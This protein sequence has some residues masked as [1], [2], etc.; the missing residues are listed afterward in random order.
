MYPWLV[1]LHVLGVFGFLMAHGVTVSAF[2]ALRR[3]RNINRIQMLL[4]MSRGSLVV[5]DISILLLLASGIIAG[6][7]GRWWSHAWIWVSL[8]LLF[9]I[10]GAMEMLGT[11]SLNNIRVALG[12]PSTRGQKPLEEPLNAE[13]MNNLLTRVQPAR[14]ASIALGGLAIIAWLM[15]FK[16]L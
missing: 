10:F 8:V 16:P 2:F 3:E 4:E 15:V 12:L 1:F 6:F 5:V 11:R 9:G 7:I 14:L 13:E